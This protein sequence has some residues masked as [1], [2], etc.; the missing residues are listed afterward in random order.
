MTP[1]L[2]KKFIPDYESI[3]VNLELEQIKNDPKT[4]KLLHLTSIHLK[5]NLYSSVTVNKKG[6]LKAIK[7]AAS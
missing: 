2:P 4:T 5:V 1:L 6:E 3:E 7:K